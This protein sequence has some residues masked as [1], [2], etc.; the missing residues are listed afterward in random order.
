MLTL[1]LSAAAIAMLTAIAWAMGFRSDPVLDEAAATAEAQGRLAGFRAADVQL[2]TDGRGALLRDAAGR[3]A[4]ILPLGDGWLV[5]RIPPDA[6][7]RYKGG[8]LHV[9]FGEPMLRDARLAV[10]RLP[11]WLEGQSA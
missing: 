2:A 5:R 7:V 1:L 6:R 4:L 8:V 11:A 9:A 10:P 3:L